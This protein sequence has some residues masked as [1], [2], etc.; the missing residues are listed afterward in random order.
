MPLPSVEPTSWPTE[1]EFGA[2]SEAQRHWLYYRTFYAVLL[3]TQNI[4]RMLWVIFGAVGS[5]AGAVIV[6][7]IQRAI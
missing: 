5:L 3:R 4:N 7:L 6:A 1:T 2:M